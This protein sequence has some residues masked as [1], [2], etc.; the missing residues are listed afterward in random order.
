MLSHVA[1]LS[2]MRIQFRFDSRE[3]KGI[4]RFKGRNI[5]WKLLKNWNLRANI[6]RLNYNCQ[7]N[8]LMLDSFLQDNIKL[9]HKEISVFKK[10]LI[11]ISNIF[12]MDCMQRIY[13]SK[14]H[15]LTFFP[16]KYIKLEYL[17][18]FLLSIIFT[19]IEIWNFS[20]VDSS[21]R[22]NITLHYTF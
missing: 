21:N 15:F 12:I 16:H 5:S 9:S 3:K 17:T 10:N 2:A 8:V 7:L 20:R 11:L 6:K 4:E 14:I 22:K 19:K 1:C 13:F 18:P